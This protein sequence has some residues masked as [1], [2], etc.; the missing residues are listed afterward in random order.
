[1]FDQIAANKRRSVLLVAVFVVL[2]VAVV[3][4][5]DVLLGYGLI[6]LVIAFVFAG[7]SSALA[8]WKSDAVA[9][10]M[11]HA[12]PADPVEYARLHNVVEGLCIAAGLPKPRVYIIDDTAPN[13]FA[14]GRDPK[15]AA[16]AV[17]TGLLEKMNRIELEGVIAHELSHVKNYDIL[18]STLAVTL[19][20]II[21]LIADWTLRA[22]WWGGRRSRSSDSPGGYGASALLAVLGFA[23]LILAPIVAKLMQFAVSRRREALAD[24]TGVSLTRYPPGLIS[25]LEKLRD[26]NTV[27]HSGSR[28]TAHLWI[29]SPVA[30]ES[31]E[32]KMAWLGR[33]FD[34]H[35]PLDERIQALRE[36]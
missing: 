8:Y 29:E 4:A 18:V 9:L 6:G 7:T 25:A 11:S 20:G 19:V 28:A 3:W 31:D 33:L 35:P 5:V 12:R 16:L 14:T 30:R 27:V 22:I 13:A 1:M 24:V 23:L 32:G 17:T 36:L 21:V 34:T 2:I 10:A 15:H 26:D